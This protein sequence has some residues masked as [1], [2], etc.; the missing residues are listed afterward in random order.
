MKHLFRFL[1]AA[2]VFCTSSAFAT[3]P[4]GFTELEYIESTGRQYIDTGQMFLF[5]DEFYF[6]YMPVKSVSSENKGYG[7]GDVVYVNSISGGGRTYTGTKSVAMFIEKNNATYIPELLYNDTLNKRYIEHWKI[8]EGK[9]DSV[10]AHVGTDNTY[11]FSA[12]RDILVPGYQSGNSIYLFRDNNEQY[13]YYSAIRLY[14]TWLQRKNT[15][16][17]FSF[18]PA[19]RNSDGEVGMY[20]TVSNTFFTNQGTGDFIAGPIAHCKTVSTDG[21]MCTTC[22]SG[23]RLDNSGG[24]VEIIEIATTKFVDEEFAATEAKLATTVQTIE[25][26]VS[27]T[28]AQTEQIQILQDTKQTRPDENC[29]A[30]MKCLLVQDEDGTPHWYPIIEP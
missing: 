9:L 19:K 8:T 10:L 24:C 25:S 14:R 13:A 26:V 6:E 4:A 5:G 29:P 22:E 16:Y 20:D 28:I 3:L 27:R 17:A 7:A 11:S 21:V 1:Y 12:N 23:Y 18:I 2:C 30:N 15:T